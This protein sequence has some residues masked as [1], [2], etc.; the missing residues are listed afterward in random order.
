MSV[1]PIYNVVISDEDGMIKMSI[2]D[3]PAVESYFLAFD[4][5]KE[6]MTFSVNDEKREVF[7]CSIRA[8]YPIY[9]YDPYM[10]EYYVT[11][12]KDAIKQLAIKGLKEN[13]FN[14]V[15]VQHFLDVE[16][17][18]LIESFIKDSE[19]GV[20]PTGFDD[21]A[22]GSLFTRYKVDNDDVWNN[23]K[24]G[25]LKGFS[26]ESY[27][28]FEIVDNKDS[29]MSEDEMLSSEIIEILNKID[30]LVKQK[31]RS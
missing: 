2:V 14:K 25:K 19:S 21:I 20:N 22:D 9:R 30:A 6:L 8:D 5:N 12:S 24:S 13:A 23:I 28:S 17:V 7:G 11:F 31:R 15:D 1:I 4:K 27:L 3:E 16:G 26:I 29:K 18:Y 10:G